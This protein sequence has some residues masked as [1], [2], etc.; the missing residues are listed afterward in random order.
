MDEKQR[1]FQHEILDGRFRYP[2]GSAN[3]MWIKRAHDIRKVDKERV[4]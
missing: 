4:G 2:Q 3:D 1:S